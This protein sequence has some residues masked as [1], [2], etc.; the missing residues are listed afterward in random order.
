MEGSPSRGATPEAEA[1]EA[2]LAGLDPKVA[3]RARAHQAG[4]PTPRLLALGNLEPGDVG[5]VEGEV[6]QV[7]PVR[8]FVRRRGGEGLVGR[9]TLGDATGEAD[10][11]LWDD[12]TRLVQDGPFTPGA[13]LRLQGVSARA[14]RRQGG[15]ELALGAAVVSTLEPEARL[16]GLEGVLVAL[17]PTRVLG[18]PPRVRFQADAELSVAGGAARLAVE[19][20]A[21]L[22]L[23]R[24]LPGV[25]VRVRGVRPHPALEGWWLATPGT[26]VL[27]G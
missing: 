17:G 11:V 13:R 27:V 6:R 8:P 21:L 23:R 26:Q 25:T 2:F 4:R 12:E 15:A 20:A 14:G 18:E 7:H 1:L 22:A 10:L 9:V 5:V 3:A 19:G 16:E 24:V